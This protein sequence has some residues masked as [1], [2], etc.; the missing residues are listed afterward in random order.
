M[1]RKKASTAH[2]SDQGS[3]YFWWFQ[4]LRANDAYRECC[5][6]TKGPHRWLLT[7]MGNVHEL[8][9]ESWWAAK[10]E[11][12]VL[13]HFTVRDISVNERV[14]PGQPGLD[15][16]KTLAAAHEVISAFDHGWRLIEINAYA[17]EERLVE[18]FTEIVRKLRREYPSGHV[19]VEFP[20]SVR[21]SASL[22]TRLARC[23][24]V[25][26]L[27]KGT[28]LPLWKLWSLARDEAPPRV[29]DKV[30]KND[31]TAS[32]SRDLNDAR[33]AIMGTLLGVFPAN[34][35]AAPHP[36]CPPRS[37]TLVLNELSGEGR[38]RRRT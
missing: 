10:H 16:K 7:R 33:R 15:V 30:S 11:L 29:L 6:T 26:E 13:P 17:P 12:F 8:S 9:F 36:M 2:L 1:T 24:R 37:A 19:E 38:K 31:R 18:D 14:G 3:I 35:H 27:A 32:V 20:L 28:D 34:R 23:L 21:D 5:M 22:R 4:Y 25:W